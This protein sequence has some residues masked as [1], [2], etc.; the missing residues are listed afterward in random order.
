[1]AETYSNELDGV[2]N[3]TTEPPVKAEGYGVGARVRVVRS[4][5]DLASQANGD[6][7][8][9]AKPQ[10]GMVFSHG[11]VTT[12]TSLGTSTI[13]IGDT[14]DSDGYRADAVLTATNTPEVFG[15]I[16]GINDTTNGPIVY[17]GSTEVKITIGTADLPASGRMVVD[18]VYLGK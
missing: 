14:N 12:D 9:I 10:A 3:A 2:L 7:I 1:M 4:T 18:L 5:I 11:L 17:D 6:T 13:S 8:V 15:T 16:P